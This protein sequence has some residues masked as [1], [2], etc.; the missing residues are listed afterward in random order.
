MF[1]L[2]EEG[3]C[4]RLYMNGFNEIVRF[5]AIKVLYKNLHNNTEMW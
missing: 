2:F 1:I 3:L 5:A 4:N